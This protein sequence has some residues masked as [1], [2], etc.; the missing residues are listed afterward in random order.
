[1][2]DE[3]NSALRLSPPDE[4]WHVACGEVSQLILY[5]YI[6]VEEDG[7]SRAV[8]VQYNFVEDVVLDRRGRFY[9]KVEKP[10]RDLI[11][12][13][14]TAV[15]TRPLPPMKKIGNTLYLKD[16]LHVFCGADGSWINADTGKIIV[17]LRK[18]TA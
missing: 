4:D 13:Y 14:N 9:P 12:T 16:H 8:F 3:E 17:G 1:L 11:R 2:L 18:P 5:H 10:S 6:L 15:R 7:D